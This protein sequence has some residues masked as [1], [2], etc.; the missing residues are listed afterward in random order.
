MYIIYDTYVYNILFN[1]TI[2]SNMIIIECSTSV[3]QRTYLLY[4]E[5]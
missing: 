4:A 5:K 2:N 1:I 3:A